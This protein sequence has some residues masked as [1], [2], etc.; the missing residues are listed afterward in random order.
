MRDISSHK[1][2]GTMHLNFFEWLFLRECAV[3]FN[4]SNNGENEISKPQIFDIGQKILTKYT[5]YDS[6]QNEML[7]N[8]LDWLKEKV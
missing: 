6:L 5:F 2:K 3:A 8:G 1:L 4:F 7:F